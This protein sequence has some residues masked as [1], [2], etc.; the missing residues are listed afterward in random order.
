MI[1]RKATG[2]V[3]SASASFSHRLGFCLP[4]FLHPAVLSDWVVWVVEVAFLEA[5]V[6]SP[7]STSRI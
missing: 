5:V 6:L 7:W 2:L 4:V 1:G 3:A